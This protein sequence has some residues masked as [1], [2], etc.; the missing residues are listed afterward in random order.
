VSHSC[1][2]VFTFA[3][4]SQCL[5]KLRTIRTMCARIQPALYETLSITLWV[6]QKNETLDI[7]LVSSGGISNEPHVCY[8]GLE[9][10]SCYAVILWK[11]T[12]ENY[13]DSSSFQLTKTD[14]H[15]W[16][17]TPYMTEEIHSIIIEKSLTIDWIHLNGIRQIKFHEERMT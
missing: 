10:P 3:I 7:I 12:S 15:V 2:H 9:D 6:E 11:A 4:M 1:Q 17:W 13:I 16:E 8:I 14:L 5:T